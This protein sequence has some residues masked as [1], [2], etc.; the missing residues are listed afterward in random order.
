M[1]KKALIKVVVVMYLRYREARMMIWL[2]QEMDFSHVQIR[3][4][5]ESYESTR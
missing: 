3:T 4:L 1:N 5:A 2:S